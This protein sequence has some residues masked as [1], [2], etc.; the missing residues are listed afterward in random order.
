MLKLCIIVQDLV[1]DEDGY[2]FDR[3]ADDF[4][5]YAQTKELSISVP[6]VM[7]EGEEDGEGDGEDGDDG[8]EDGEEDGEDDGEDAQTSELSCYA[9][10][11][12]GGGEEDGE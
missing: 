8:E 6:K 12:M 3:D 7:D 1:Q 5:G 9:P 10:K 4:P 11:A 2:Y